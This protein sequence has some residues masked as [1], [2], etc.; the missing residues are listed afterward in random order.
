MVLY[1]RGTISYK[2]GLRGWVG[3]TKG[4]TKGG[5]RGVTH[6]VT[7]RQSSPMVIAMTVDDHDVMTVEGL[8][9]ELCEWCRRACL[10]PAHRQRS[11]RE[12]ACHCLPW[13]GPIRG[14]V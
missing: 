3:G 6:L 8:L 4:G 12:Q 13:P 11:R 14:M 5:R 2:L 10:V 9:R 1:E 7:D